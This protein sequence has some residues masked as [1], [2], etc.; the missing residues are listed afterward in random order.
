MS[1]EIALAVLVDT[2]ML[3]IACGERFAQGMES[4]FWAMNPSGR[5]AGDAVCP[6]CNRRMDSDEAQEA[7]GRVVQFLNGE[8]T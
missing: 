3:C 6:H 5:C 4:L 2:E 8:I 7:S 1:G